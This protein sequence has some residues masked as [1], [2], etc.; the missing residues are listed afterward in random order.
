MLPEVWLKKYNVDM[1]L[2][3]K[4][5]LGII[6]R[7]CLICGAGYAGYATALYEHGVRDWLVW[8]VSSLLFVIAAGLLWRV[9]RNDKKT[10]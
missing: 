2:K 7:I 1:D 8:A 6:E 4:R 10:T 5:N 3:R 9:Q